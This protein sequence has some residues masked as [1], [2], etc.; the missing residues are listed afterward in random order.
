MTSSV[1]LFVYLTYIQNISET[2]PGI[3]KWKNSFQAFMEVSMITP[4]IS[5]DEH[6]YHNST[7]QKPFSI[8]TADYSSVWILSNDHYVYMSDLCYEPKTNYC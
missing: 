4:S 2:D 5:R 6:F 7:F 1:V 3:S 8:Q